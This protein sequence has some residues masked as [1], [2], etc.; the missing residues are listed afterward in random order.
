MDGA[1][2]QIGIIEITIRIRGGKI[3]VH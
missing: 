3:G 2:I 1:Q